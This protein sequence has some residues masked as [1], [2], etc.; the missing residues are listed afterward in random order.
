MILEL[1]AIYYF[2]IYELEGKKDSIVQ[3]WNRNYEKLRNKYV[4]EFY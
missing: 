1:C 2:G 4:K 3:T